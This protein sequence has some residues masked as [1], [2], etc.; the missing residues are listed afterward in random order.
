MVMGIRSPVGVADRRRAAGAPEVALES[1]IINHLRHRP[2]S[3]R[4]HT[5][6][7]VILHPPIRHRHL[8]I[9]HIYILR[10]DLS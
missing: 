10:E 9:R 2:A 7:G 1:L 8:R 5:L 3:I 4:Y 6:M